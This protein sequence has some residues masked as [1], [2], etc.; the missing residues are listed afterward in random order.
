MARRSSSPLPEAPRAGGDAIAELIREIVRDEV[1]RAMAAMERPASDEFMSTGAAA[2][3][4]SVAGGT[5]RRWIREG[6][7]AGHKAGRVVRVKR[8]DLERLLGEGAR[9][10]E[11]REHTPEEM[12]RRDFG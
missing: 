6:K 7:L 5:I 10:D 3:F 9:P 2:A 11:D 12:A 1:R 4:A 8:A